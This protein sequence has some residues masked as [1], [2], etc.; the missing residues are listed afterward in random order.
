MAWCKVLQECSRS[1]WKSPPSLAHLFSE[2]HRHIAVISSFHLLCAIGQ[3][4]NCWNN[5]R[6]FSF[7]DVWQTGQ[8]AISH[9]VSK[10]VGYLGPE[11]GNVF[12][13]WIT[14]LS[15]LHMHNLYILR[16]TGIDF[17]SLQQLEGFFFAMWPT[18]MLHAIFVFPVTC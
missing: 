14:P 7:H 15:N 12:C 4:R 11:P 3:H 6:T 9:R 8:W 1:I 17:T 2:I 5:P 18:S 16:L 13:P 10:H